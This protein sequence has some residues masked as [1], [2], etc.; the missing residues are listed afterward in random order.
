MQHRGSG[1][2]TSNQI[3]ATLQLTNRG[4]TPVSLATTTIRYWFTGDAP[5]ATYQVWCD[6]AQIG[7]AGVQV[8][9]VKLPATRTGADAYA[10][11]SFASGNLAAGASTGEI[12]VRVA[13]SDWSSFNQADDHS[14]RIS[15]SLTDFDRVTAHTGGS[16]AWGVEP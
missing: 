2:A 9:V 8:R 3:G 6:W 14:Y 7:C 11:V 5:S 13:K 15:N 16:R 10:E 1:A 4:T 12:Q